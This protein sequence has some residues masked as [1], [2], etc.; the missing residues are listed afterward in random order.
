MKS[1]ILVIDK[2]QGVTSHDL[3]A[4]VRAQLGIRKVGHAGTLDP[5][6]TGALIIG[7][8]QATRLL[9]VIVDHDKTYETTIRLGQAT[10]TDDAEGTVLP[11]PPQVVERIERVTQSQ[12][13]N[14][15]ANHYTGNIQQVPNAY[16]AIKVDGKRAYELARQGQVVALKARNINVSEYSLLGFKRTVADNGQAVIDIQARI[17]CSSGTYIRALGRDLGRELGVGG[18]LTYLRRTRVGRFD[19]SNVSLSQHVLTAHVVPHTFRDREG[20]YQT[21][22]KAILDQDRAQILARAISLVQGAKMA[23]PSL[24][25]SLEQAQ[26]LEHGQFLNLPLTEPAAAVLTLEDKEEHLIALVEPRGKDTAKPSAVF[27]FE[28]TYNKPIQEASGKQI[29]SR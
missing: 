5:M 4:A 23:M 8:G 24:P 15:I 18:H 1:G 3:V 11:S 27:P 25:V 2:P 16:S 13:E 7:F 17:S 19:I 21:K 29:G 28:P 26:A 20:L 14:I 22:N 10:Q 9:N 12:V 6:A